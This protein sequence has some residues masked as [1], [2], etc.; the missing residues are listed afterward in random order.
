VLVPKKAV[1]NRYE[2]P[3]VFLGNSGAEIK[4]LVL[5]QT[6]NHLI[7]ADDPRLPPGTRLRNRAVSR[8]ELD[9]GP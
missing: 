3:R 2:N 1:V 7:I 6:K 8:L 4:V 9:R 5:G